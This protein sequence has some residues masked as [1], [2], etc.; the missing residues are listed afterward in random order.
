MKPLEINEN[1]RFSSVAHFIFQGPAGRTVR[2]P[3]GWVEA[4][5][6]SRRNF[7]G[8]VE[9]GEPI[10]GVTTGFGD[11]SFRRVDI[12]KSEL[13]QE[14]LIRYLSCGTGPILKR[15]VRRAICLFRYLSLA[16]GLSGVSCELIESMQSLIEADWLPLIPAEGSLGASG[17]LIPLAYLASALQGVGEIETPDGIRDAAT[18]FSQTGRQ[19]YQLKSKEGL[20]LVN[21][22]S[23]MV[24]Q[25]YVNVAEAE[26]LLELATLET[27]WLCLVLSGRDEAFGPLVNERAKQFTGQSG[28]ARKIRWILEAE[29]YRVR[30][31]T[32]AD[33]VKET[34]IQDRYS[35]RCAPQILGPVADTISLVKR[36]VEIE[37]NG[38]SD[39][40]LVD[41]HDGSLNS[42]GN[43][44]GGYLSQGMDYL[45]ISLAHTAD[46]LDRQIA[47]LIDEK[48][49]RG[50][51][52]NLAN[53][54]AIP[55]GERTLHHGLKGLHQAIS[56]ITSEVMARSI[57]VGIFSR[58]SESHNQDKVSLGMGAAVS[59]ESMLD[60]LFT[61]HAMALICLTQAIDLREI[62]LKGT[63]SKKWFD[64][65][66]SVVPFVD[67]DKPLDKAIGALSS[68]L[69]K[70]WM[71]ADSF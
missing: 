29:D 25:A 42:G 56:A 38:V 8:R 30:R 41:P 43:F 17:D 22:T 9:E 36:W 7:I 40:P 46:L 13:L 4:V 68:H 47:L 28:V 3:P 12:T 48:S 71:N 66:R 6:S 65:I 23:A 1:I 53:W 26:F 31:L 60:Q 10:Y 52:P 64:R 49:N 67:K 39:N 35:L 16:R 61:I 69:R 59:C 24:G 19:P 50:L 55:E 20:A 57:P 32:A 70:E 51:S 34:A 27:G 58:S 54:P 14:N 15:P 21:G 63:G 62:K 5:A 45:K 37:I 44:Y 33:L 2:L 18:L 11:S